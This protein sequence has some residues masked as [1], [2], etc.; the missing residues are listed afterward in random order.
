MLIFPSCRAAFALCKPLRAS[1]CMVARYFSRFH[2]L[3]SIS[4][5]RI[6]TSPWR[7]IHP[8]MT[9]STAEVVSGEAKKVSRSRRSPPASSSEG[10]IWTMGPFGEC[11]VRFVGR[12]MQVAS[13]LA[14]GWKSVHLPLCKRVRMVF[15][16]QRAAIPLLC[17]QN[18]V[19]SASIGWPV[20]VQVAARSSSMQGSQSD[21]FSRRKTM[22]MLKTC[23]R[24]LSRGR[25]HRFI[26]DEIHQPCAYWFRKTLSGRGMERW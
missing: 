19:P 12:L 1:G 14:T 20:A 13:S 10:T 23:R 7:S 21:A 8:A 25:I 18:S 26:L 9:A 24:A 15:Q 16:L 4:T 22:Q 3:E 17:S 5:L 6:G 11:R 2:V